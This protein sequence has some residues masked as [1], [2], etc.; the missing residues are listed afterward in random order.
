MATFSFAVNHGYF[1]ETGTYNHQG[2]NNPVAELTTSNT[3]KNIIVTVYPVWYEHVV[4]QWEIPADWGACLFNVYFSPTENQEDFELL[5]QTPLNATYLQDIET[6]EFRKFHR[7]YYI[8]EAILTNQNDVR[9]KSLPSTWDNFQNKWV[10][11]RSHEIQR[12]EYLL[13]SRFA[14]TKAYAFR[15]KNYGA[16]CPICWSYLA[17][18]VIMDHCTE[19]MG[20]SWDGGYFEAAPCFVQFDASPQANL[21]QYIGILEA[22]QI[23]AWTISYPELH[24]DDIVI[25]TGSWE[26]YRIEQVIPT[27]LQGNT[28]RQML[29]LTQLAKGD[30]ENNL[31][32]RNLPEYPSQYR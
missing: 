26:V 25:R 4:V 12:R 17:E 13:L 15:K 5:N 19:C 32:D 14:G 10:A 16:R 24:P 18:K 6:L 31:V 8:V 9:I 28:V 23:G 20:T 1:I 3:S 22:N 11:L 30:V 21:K 2:S 7:A 29:K 27:E